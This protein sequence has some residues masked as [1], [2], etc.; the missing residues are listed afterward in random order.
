MKN[1][2]LSFCCLL[3]SLTFFS[4][5]NFSGTTGLFAKKTDREKYE[6]KLVK[7]SGKK[8]P[9]VNAWLGAGERALHSPLAV[10]LPYAETGIFY[11]V[12]GSANALKVTVKRGQQLT[13]QLNKTYPAA[14]S[15]YLDLWHTGDSLAGIEPSFIMAA[16]TVRH[17]LEYV[18]EKDEQLLIRYQQQLSATGGYSIALHAGPSFVFPLGA[19]VKSNIGSFWGA[20]RDAGIRKH[21]GIDIFAPARSPAVAV[22]N[23][24]IT[25]V[26]E[27][28]L[29]GRVV[30]L[31]PEN[32]SYNVY[33]AHLDQQL[34]S[35]GQRVSAGE[36]IGLTGN[37]GNAK[38]TPSHLHFGIYTFGGAIDPLAF[39]EPVKN[40]KAAFPAKEIK[41]EMITIQQT[42]VFTDIT[43]PAA[44]FTTLAKNIPLQAEAFNGRYYRVILP[45]G[46]K[47]FA[48]ASHLAENRSLK[49]NV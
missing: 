31:R 42:R 8:N 6:D 21:E 35:E 39:V 48:E 1:N 40:S 38:N 37:T 36:V 2:L 19:A 9:Y 29:G 45:G 28:N 46:A 26:S 44:P 34:V 15:V 24:V 16:D 49:K 20:G 32:S 30:F 23:G 47:G 43:T 11:A 10:A 27:N 18:A 3:F 12:E 4:S 7:D 25:S 41:K 22:A 14:Y 17:Q 5:C 33:Y 13:V